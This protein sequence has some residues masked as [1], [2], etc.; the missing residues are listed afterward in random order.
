MFEKLTSPLA[1]SS[2]GA[3]IIAL[4]IAGYSFSK[5]NIESGMCDLSIY[6][7]IHVYFEF[8]LIPIS[9]WYLTFKI[10]C[11]PRRFFLCNSNDLNV[12]KVCARFFD[13]FL[14][15][16][17][18][19]ITFM[20]IV[21]YLENSL[22]FN[23]VQYL[24]TTLLK[25]WVS[26]MLLSDV[27]TMFMNKPDIVSEFWSLNKKIL[28]LFFAFVAFVF[29]V[30]LIVLVSILHGKA[31]PTNTLIVVNFTE[32]LQI[33]IGAFQVLFSLFIFSSS[34]SATFR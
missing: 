9:I 34:S 11:E 32:A 20:P 31:L 24:V 25:V 27:V 4:L 12:S 6:S 19:N 7:T 22:Y 13:R 3:L 18:I 8:I 26:G 15:P 2:L 33:A 29:A 23:N 5:F 30:A 21:F 1:V 17:I 28:H 10:F 14:I 16:T